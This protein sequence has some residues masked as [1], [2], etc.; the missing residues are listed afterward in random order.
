MNAATDNPLR[1]RRGHGHADLPEELIV[2]GGNFHGQPV[3]LA[4]DVLA[5]HMTQLQTICERRVEQ[6]VNPSLSG[7]HAFLA[8][9]RVST[10]AS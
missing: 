7:L 8:Q 3:S 6:L 5:I 1:L 10:R 2:S 4:L 9:T